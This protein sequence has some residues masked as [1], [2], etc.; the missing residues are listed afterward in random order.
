M[1]SN[2]H[3][4]RTERLGAYGFR[5]VVAFSSFHKTCEVRVNRQT[6]LE[7]MMRVFG[8][9]PFRKLFAIHSTEN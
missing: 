9:T 6:T 4:Y 5:R 3:D 1:A 7:S 8:E 2:G